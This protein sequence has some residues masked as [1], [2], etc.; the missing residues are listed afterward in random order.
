MLA[1][2][3]QNIKQ[4]MKEL[5]QDSHSCI[6]PAESVIPEQHRDQSSHFF[7]SEQEK[8]PTGEVEEE[9]TEEEKD[10]GENQTV[11]EGKVT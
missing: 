11:E 1:Q 8:I 3:L 9:I 5:W 7:I 4:E 10:I 2:I 6:T